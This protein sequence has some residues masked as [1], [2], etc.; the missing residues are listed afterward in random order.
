MSILLERKNCPPLI[1]TLPRKKVGSTTL[2]MEL[3]LTIY[4][5]ELITE[6]F[7][8]HGVPWNG[9]YYCKVTRRV[10]N[11]NIEVGD[12]VV[13]KNAVGLH[14]VL[15]II[16]NKQF[17]KVLL[18]DPP[19]QSVLEV[20]FSEVDSVEGKASNNQKERLDDLFKSYYAAKVLLGI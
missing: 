6:F 9:N 7:K 15:V 12:T 3:D 13:V 5:L 1:Q 10:D 14:T 19:L 8:Y 4:I 16:R 18:A 20:K 2:L 11:F 17:N